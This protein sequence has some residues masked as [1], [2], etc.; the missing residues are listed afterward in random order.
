M[1]RSLR[2]AQDARKFMRHA[3]RDVLATQDVEEA[4]RLR[5][6]EVPDT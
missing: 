3:K 6:I 2:P 1:T 4:F 5:N